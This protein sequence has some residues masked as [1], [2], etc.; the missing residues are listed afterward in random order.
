M[1]GGYTGKFLDVDLSK[2]KLKNTTFNEETLQAYFGGRGLAAKILWDRLGKKWGTIDALSPENLFLALTGPMTA[3][4]P[5]ARIMCS[6]K[7]PRQQRGRR[8]NCKHRVRLRDQNGRLRW[9][10]S[11]G[12]SR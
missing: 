11:L 12:E 8:I 5:G 4:Y 7:K 9:R 6:G 10:N 3:I 1:P 2:R